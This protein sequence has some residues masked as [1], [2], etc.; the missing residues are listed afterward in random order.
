[1]NRRSFLR[2]AAQTSGL[3]L[4][5]AYGPAAHRAPTATPSE[6]TGLSDATLRV[7][8]IG[9]PPTLDYHFTTASITHIIAWNIY[10][11]LVSL[12]HNFEPKPM[13]ADSWEVSPD[14]LTYTFHLRKG[15]RFHNDKELKADDVVASLG[16]WG[17][18]S[19]T[20]GG[21]F[22]RVRSLDKRDDYTVVLQLAR[23]Y[24]SLLSNLAYFAQAPVIMPR[25]IAESAGKEE[26][27]EYVG[28]GPYRFIEW[29]PG[30][31]IK[32]TRFEDYR[33]RPEPGD[34]ESGGQIPIIKDVFF[35]GQPDVSARLAGLQAG[36]YDF[37]M[38]LS[39][40]QYQT[41]QSLA[42]IKTQLLKT[43]YYPVLVHNAK[44][45]PCDN[46]KFRQAVAAIF[47]SAAIM[48]PLGP[49][50][51]WQLDPS[52]MPFGRWRTEAGKEFYNQ[53][54]PERARQ[55]LREAG[56]NGEVLTYL[57]SRQYDFVDK[58]AQ[59][60]TQQMRA[61]GLNVNLE[62]LDW[63]TLIAR[64]SQESGWHFFTTGW[65]MPNDPSL[66]PFL[67]CA[68]KWPGFYCNPD[69]DRLLDEFQ[70]E[71]SFEGQYRVWE[72]IQALFWSDAHIIKWGDYFGVYAMQQNVDG[73]DGFIDFRVA[74]IRKS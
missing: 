74:G 41:L 8:T 51:F 55:L 53:N 3:M 11:K 56:Y 36:D 47:D 14:G 49:Q 71:V 64:R 72:R 15:V 33:P 19:A 50:E 10:E 25:E 39:A 13:L 57:S 31:H 30:V 73:W 18:L 2:A 5:A 44:A 9:E 24:G 35:L 65:V 42:D 37:A 40:D 21:L 6:P 38:N 12:D 46:V 28:T 45:P 70:G 48:E 23:K 34:G 7:A 17:K 43:Y 63:A 61:A 59:V 54:N 22:Q 4:L 52:F 26:I 1:M 66:F 68:G 60:A 69:M 58:P 27:T 20:G 67:P 29:K 62:V 16:R 32:L